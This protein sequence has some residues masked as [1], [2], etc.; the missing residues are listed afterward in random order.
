MTFF[1]NKKIIYFISFAIRFDN[2]DLAIGNGFIETKFCLFVKPNKIQEW[3]S[4]IKERCLNVDGVCVMTF[5]YIPFLDFR[6]K[7]EEFR[8]DI[9]SVLM[10]PS[11]RYAEKM[12]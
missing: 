4:I 9:M 1:W 12:E 3:E 11:A 6:T 2:G 8:F 10:P 7:R 5:E